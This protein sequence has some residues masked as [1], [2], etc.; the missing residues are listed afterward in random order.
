[1]GRKRFLGIFVNPLYVQNEGLEQVFDNIESVEARAICLSLAVACPAEDGGRFPPLHVDGYERLVARPVWGRREIRLE[2]F[3]TFEPELSIY[4]AA[5]YKPLAKPVPPEVDIGI[6]ERMMAEAKRRGMEV[7]L[8]FGPFVPP[9]VRAE[10]RP[11]VVD[12]AVPQP[13]RVALN[14]CLNSPAAQAYA[15]ALSEDVARH[16]PGVDGLIPDWAE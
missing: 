12:G 6:P 4:E 10:D 13:P 11:V 1:M 14:A 7:H 9:G 5:P 16:Y 2:R 3:R 15:L 8:M